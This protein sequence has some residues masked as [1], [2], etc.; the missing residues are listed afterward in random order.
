M[1]M[2]VACWAQ[3]GAGFLPGCIGALWGVL[4]GGRLL[5]RVC[6]E[7]RRGRPLQ[8]SGNWTGTVH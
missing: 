5:K 2:K 6:G 7:E 8:A 1:K 4:V 3:A